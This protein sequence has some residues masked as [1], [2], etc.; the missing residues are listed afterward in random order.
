MSQIFGGDFCKQ[1]GAARQ[2]LSNVT[3][4]SSAVR[5]GKHLTPC[6]HRLW[7]LNPRLLQ[8]Q[9]IYWPSSKKKKKKKKLPHTTGASMAAGLLR[10]SKRKVTAKTSIILSRLGYSIHLCMCKCMWMKAWCAHTSVSE[11][12]ECS[13]L[14][15][16]VEMSHR[17]CP[18]YWDEC[19]V[20]KVNNN[21]EKWK[22]LLLLLIFQLKMFPDYWLIILKAFPL[23]GPGSRLSLDVF[24]GCKIQTPNAASGSIKSATKQKKK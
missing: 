9:S 3:R 19:R 20:T 23:R 8:L 14:T 6:R 5:A 13:L 24:N 7:E 1:T 17:L 15:G 21:H 12:W 11:V 4:C 22:T 18:A 16:Y 10:S 2:I